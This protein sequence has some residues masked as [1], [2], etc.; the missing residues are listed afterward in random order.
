MITRVFVTYI[1]YKDEMSI[2]FALISSLEK[3]FCTG[4]WNFTN[5]TFGS[6]LRNER[7]SF[8]LAGKAE[9]ESRSRIPLKLEITS[10]IAEYIRVWR[11]GYVPSLLPSK[12][13]CEDDDYITKQPGLFPDPLYPVIDGEIE[14]AANQ[15]RAFWFSV[16]PNGSHAGTYPIHICIS[17]PKGEQAA[18]LTYTIE[19][20]DAD[21]PPQRLVSTGWFHCDGLAVQ[22]GVEPLSDAHFAII[23]KYM[24]VYAAFGHNMI[25]TPVFTPPLDTE[26]GGERLT[27]QLVDVTVQ[28]GKYVFGFEKLE[29]WIEI[30]E[31]CGIRYFEISHLFT[32]WGAKCAPKIM[33]SVDGTYQKIS[34]WETEAQSEDYR[35]FLAAF[36][37]GLN[38]FLQK[39]GV[40]DRTYFHVSDEPGA[41]HL[42][43]YRAAKEQLISYVNGYPVIDALSDYSFYE[44]GAVSKP[45]V[46]TNHVQTFLDHGV[47]NLWVYYCTS[48]GSL[49]ANRFM[50]QPSY[51]NRILGYQLYKYDIA[52]FLHWGFNFWN[53]QFSLR[54]IN[55]Y[56]VT[57][58][59]GGFQ[60]GDA[61]VVYPLDERGEVV[62]SFR[63]FVF[64]EGL[65][66]LRALRLLEERIGRS[67]VMEL[68]EGIEGF[69]N[70][71][72]NPEY[73]LQLR[74]KINEKIKEMLE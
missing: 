12:R 29:R 69:D 46:A 65:Q 53:S 58:A 63:L 15:N 41:E 25:L 13:E 73:I 55:P 26:V 7:Y 34:G 72:R 50:A 67:A 27:I 40:A 31:R 3:V 54:A 2:R 10:P 44:T 4:E 19:I 62:C 66:D 39:S 37:P 56:A 68:L 51:R 32:Q 14:L 1:S 11:V 17:T 45:I 16:E 5:Q 42:E 20:I 70:Y 33:A 23:E 8:Q 52:G 57:D 36:L 6:M 30:A 21:L 59:D 24:R 28:N 43:S 64:A 38:A 22:H 35:N 74:Q 71:P 9:G 61:F 60:S 18:E 48:Q 49:V 47:E